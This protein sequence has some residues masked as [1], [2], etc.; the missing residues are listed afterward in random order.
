MTE[1][2]RRARDAF[3]DTVLTRDKFTCQV[4]PHKFNCGGPLDA[5][6]IPKAQTLRA[7]TSTLDEEEALSIIYDPDLA[8]CVCRTAHTPLTSKA[9]HLTPAQV[10]NRAI[11]AA[12]K[13]RIGWMLEREVPGFRET[14]PDVPLDPKGSQ[15]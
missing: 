1:A 12:H 14:V 6:H 2:E 7:H 10:P 11:E 3:N 15:R 4:A 5:H 9:W 8:I 13:Y